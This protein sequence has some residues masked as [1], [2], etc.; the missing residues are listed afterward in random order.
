[1]DKTV[2]SYFS[3]GLAPSSQ[4][5]YT[6]GIRQ[7]IE[8]HQHFQLSRL[9]MTELHLCRFVTALAN[10]NVSHGTIKVYLSGVRQLH[11]K[12]GY[13]PPETGVMA[14]LQQVLKG[15][16]IVQSKAIVPRQR[17]PITPAM[18]TRIRET[19]GKRDNT[20]FFEVG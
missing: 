4:R 11:L 1:M 3:Q 6:T 2:E 5:V 19:W 17:N 15:I 10:D 12:E 8:F 13:K 7:Y 18:L 9:P 16:K 20:C 14:R